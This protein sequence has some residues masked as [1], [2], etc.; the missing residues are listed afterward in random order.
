[1]DLAGVAGLR[2]PLSS[3][4]LSRS[5]KQVEPGGTRQSRWVSDGAIE[6]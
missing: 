1:M 6:L 2:A 3:L 4:R 5:E